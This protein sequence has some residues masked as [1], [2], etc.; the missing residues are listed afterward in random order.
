M[1]FPHLIPRGLYLFMNFKKNNFEYNLCIILAIV[2][3]LGLLIFSETLLNKLLLIVIIATL[4]F[5]II[6]LRK[7]KKDS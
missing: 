6:K 3:N 2:I 1:H 4:L 5:P 7:N